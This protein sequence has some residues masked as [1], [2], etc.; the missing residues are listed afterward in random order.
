[1]RMVH[2]SSSLSLVNDGDLVWNSVGILSEHACR[3]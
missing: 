3:R 2:F 1:L